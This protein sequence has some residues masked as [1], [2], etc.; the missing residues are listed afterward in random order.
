MKL[1]IVHCLCISTVTILLCVVQT[2]LFCASAESHSTE[3]DYAE[4]SSAERYSDEYHEAMFCSIEC[5]S[6]ESH[7]DKYFSAVFHSAEC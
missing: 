2:F 3:C 4:C 7:P 1:S 5:S 6:N